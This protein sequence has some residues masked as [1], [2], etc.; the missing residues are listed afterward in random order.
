VTKTLND[1]KVDIF[2]FKVGRNREEMMEGDKVTKVIKVRKKGGQEI[3]TGRNHS[4]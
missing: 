1:R 2:Y 4:P 3:K